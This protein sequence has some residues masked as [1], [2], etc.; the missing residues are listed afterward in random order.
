MQNPD[1]S[2]VLSSCEPELQ[3]LMRQ[4]DIMIYHQKRHWEADVRAL[5]LRVK[6]GEEELLTSKNIIERRNL[7]IGLLHKQ[8]EDILTHYQ[9]L[10]S[11]SEQQLQKVQEELDKLKRS[12][13]KLQRKQLK[14]ADGGA[15]ETELS[16]EYQ[17]RS[18]E[19]EQLRALHQ[20][21]VTTLEAQNKSLM[22]ELFD[23]KNKWASWQVDHRVCCSELQCLR[24]ELEKAQATVHSQERELERLRPFETL[25]ERYQKEQSCL[26]QE[27]HRLRQELAKM[28]PQLHGPN[29]PCQ[30]NYERALLSHAI[31]DQPQPDQDGFQV[32]ENT[33]HY[34]G[35]I[36]RL[37]KELQ[38]LSQTP[39]EQLHSQTQNT[40]IHSSSSSSSSSS[41]LS[42]CSTR[43]TKRASV[44]TLSPN[45]PA[46]GGQSSDSEDFLTSGS[47]K[48]GIPSPSL[49]GPLSVLPAHGTISRFLEEESLRSEELLQKLD[50]HIQGMKEDNTRTVSKYRTSGSGPEADQSS[51][52]SGR[53]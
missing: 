9:E 30:E 19:W 18:A 40:R 12:Y 3:E 20:N 37:F 10:V 39:T 49:E 46:A 50:L 52:H 25:T 28:R 38:N 23:M 34:E 48:K 21:Q 44:P 17:Q 47:R 31:A 6:S 33:T 8:I 53:Q 1:L 5:E 45:K 27:N 24:A 7:E 15:K 43:L 4:I 32:Q 22:E 36:Q 11:K 42:S 35:E 16:K 51:E 14:E 2:S 13:Q 29:Q 26:E 41:F